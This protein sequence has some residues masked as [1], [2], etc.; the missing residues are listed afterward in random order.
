MNLVGLK[1]L[2]DYA[3][4]VSVAVSEIEARGIIDG[5]M[6]GSLK[7]VI[8]STESFPSAGWAVKVGSIQAI[9]L[10]PLEIQQGPMTPGGKLI[11]G[12]FPKGN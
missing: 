1:F 2:L 8:G 12:Y 4:F 6:K 11:S 9:H 5:W 3:S 7:S 10:F